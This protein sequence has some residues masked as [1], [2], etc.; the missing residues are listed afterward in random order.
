[1]YNIPIKVWILDNHPFVPPLV[2]VTPT[3]TMVIK[4]GKH[5][6]TTGR[7]YLPYLSDWKSVSTLLVTLKKNENLV[8]SRQKSEFTGGGGGVLG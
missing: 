5:V 2:F 4:P 6:D 8:C 3:S 7:V 1:M